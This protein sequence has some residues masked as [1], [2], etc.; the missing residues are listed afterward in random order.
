MTEE[1]GAAPHGRPTL[2][3]IGGTGA[4]GMGLAMRWAAAGYPVVLGSRSSEKAKARRRCAAM[5]MLVRRARA[6]L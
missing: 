4:L 3:I 2:A 5:T 1:G 6:T